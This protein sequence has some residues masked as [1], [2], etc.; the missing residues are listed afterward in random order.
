MK[1]F[2]VLSLFGL[3]IMGFSAT[4]YA[5]KVDFA[6]SGFFAAGG[7]ASRNFLSSPLGVGPITN[8][9]TPNVSTTSFDHP[10]AFFESAG[11]LTFDFSV[12]KQITGRFAFDFL[13]YRSGYSNFSTA[14]TSWPQF[15]GGP[16]GARTNAIRVL[17]VYFDFAL[18]YFG[19][20]APMSVRLGVQPLGARGNVFMST[21]GAGVTGNIKFDPASIQLQWGKMVEGKDAAADDSDIYGAIFTTKVATMSFGAFLFYMNANTYPL[22]YPTTVP[23][24]SVYG[25]TGYP[26]DT[27]DFWWFGLNSDGKMGPV[28]YNFDFVYDKGK[29]E[30]RI[31]PT[32]DDV[33]YSGWMTQM[34]VA[35]PYDKFTFGALGLYSSGADLKKTSTGGLPNTTVANTSSGSALTTKVDA[36]VVPPNSDTWLLWWE[37][38]FLGGMPATLISGPYGIAGASSTQVNRNS[39]GGTW[40]GKL[41]ASYQVTPSYKLTLH[42][43]YIGDTT[44]NGNT[45]G[46]AVK[47][48]DTLR[49]DKT[50]GWELTLIQDV[51]IYKN[52]SLTLGTGILIPGDALDQRLSAGVNKTPKDPYAAV[53]KFMYVF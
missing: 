11:A 43:L 48:D 32:A 40:I 12:E 49:D 22:E 24:T 38:L 37:S 2:I 31:T 6:A 20:P 1:K 17:N 30:S 16:W 5:Q 44:K 7:I 28:N 47:A 15:Y 39:F 23:T 33:K 35:Y 14:G 8:Y 13:N 3:L 41:F 36:Y 29:V 45:I 10:N 9:S 18:P 52:L 21:P 51:Q 26:A 34:K 46:N 42:G 19:I 25:T 4:V 27:A 50:I 53:A